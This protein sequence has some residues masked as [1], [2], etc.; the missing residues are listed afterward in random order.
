MGCVFK[1]QQ[2][3]LPSLKKVI[4]QEQP[5]HMAPLVEITNVLFILKPQESLW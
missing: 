4:V 1:A 3:L 2:S 5:S